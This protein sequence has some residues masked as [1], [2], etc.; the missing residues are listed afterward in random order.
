MYH[1]RGWTAVEASITDLLYAAAAYD[2]SSAPSLSHISLASP[3]KPAASCS[4][5]TKPLAAR[6]LTAG[7][8]KTVFHADVIRCRSLTSTPIQPARHPVF[9]LSSHHTAH[10]KRQPVI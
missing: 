4:H 5:L 7:I 9:K 8:P 1:H 6:T 2:T 10:A 3:E